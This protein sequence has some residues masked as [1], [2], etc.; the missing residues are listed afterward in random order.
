MPSF[1]IYFDFYIWPRLRNAYLAHSA[2]ALFFSS[3]P[4]V[5]ERKDCIVEFMS[6]CKT[7]HI[8]GT[9]DLPVHLMSICM[10]VSLNCI[11]V[12][13][14]AY[15]Y[16]CMRINGIYVLC[17]THHIWRTIDHPVHLDLKLETPGRSFSPEIERLC[18]K[19]Q[20]QIGLVYHKW[21]EM[22][23]DFSFPSLL[24][25]LFAFN[26]NQVTCSLPSGQCILDGPNG[27]WDDEDKENQK[28]AKARASA[29]SVLASILI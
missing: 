6:L 18:S 5:G 9:I 15:L 20:M 26:L 1:I 4:W 8:R 19:L 13:V 10:C 25:F 16:L 23:T 2:F 7:H 27:S 22:Y 28:W 14:C 12:F 24:L 17:K 11:F 3:V 29:S 21:D